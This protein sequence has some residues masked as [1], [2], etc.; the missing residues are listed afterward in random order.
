MR[1]ITILAVILLFSALSAAQT[2]ETVIGP[3]I[4]GKIERYKN[5][6]SDKVAP[7]NVDVWQN[8][9]E[10]H[11]DEVL[12]KLIA[13]KKVRETIIVGVWNTPKRREEYMPQKA[14]EMASADQ[15][16]EAATFG[17]TGVVSD[18]YLKFLVDELKP[19]IDRNFPTKRDRGNTFVMGSSMGGLI[20][21]YAISEY[22]NIFGGAGCL[23][24]H[25]PAGNG[26]M[27]DYIR[28]NLPSPKNHRIYFDYGTA[29][30]DS[31][32]EPFQL[33]ADDLMRAK[34]FT[35]ESWITKKFEGDDHSEKAGR[36]GWTFRSNSCSETESKAPDRKRPA[37][38]RKRLRTGAQASPLATA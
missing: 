10:W 13:E 33:R 34:G 29:T 21:L 25:F 18:N 22:P 14:F 11:A 38:E 20:S 26:V 32:Y 3:N 9:Q 30:L 8:K 6:P 28:S 27:I 1:T 23:S 24:T 19:F 16:K 37:L 35:A 36:N 2:P 12:A 7:R 5:F 31:S 15:K 4:T 17:I